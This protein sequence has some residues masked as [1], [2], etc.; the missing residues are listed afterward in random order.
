MTQRGSV[1]VRLLCS[2]VLFVR[3]LCLFVC[4]VCSF[5]VFVRLLC[6]FVCCVLSSALSV[7]CV[8]VG[9]FAD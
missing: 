2:F 8:R 5:V 9:L 6:L 3:L 7:F 1:L 4:C